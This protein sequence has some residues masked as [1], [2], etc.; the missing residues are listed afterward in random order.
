[1]EISFKGHWTAVMDDFRTFSEE[2]T[3]KKKLERIL[4]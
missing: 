2:A 3:G 1:M 4:V